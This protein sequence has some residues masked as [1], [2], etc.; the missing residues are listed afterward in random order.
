MN[1][2]TSGR[3]SKLLSAAGH[4][5][6]VGV[7]GW[8]WVTP[9]RS[10]GFSTQA[11]SSSEPSSTF[12]SGV[13]TVPVDV[14]RRFADISLLGAFPLAVPVLLAAL[15]TWAAWRNRKLV[16]LLATVAL[17]AFCVL[18]A[19]SIGAGYVLGGGAML[20]ALLVRFE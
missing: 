5:W 12:S 1:A 11:W 13:R 2:R 7:S 10:S 14:S 17:L 4:L 20:W 19:F 9:I 3:I 6:C 15:A 18:A 16:L 8:I